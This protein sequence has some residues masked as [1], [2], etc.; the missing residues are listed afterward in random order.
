MGGEGKD[1]LTILN[2]FE[3]FSDNKFSNSRIMAKIELSKLH[4]KVKQIFL[5]G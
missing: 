4:R 2:L 5:M 1:M 3:G